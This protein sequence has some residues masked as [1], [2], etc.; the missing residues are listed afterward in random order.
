MNE[1]ISIKDGL[2]EK[3]IEVL[4]FRPYPNEITVSFL[5][6]MLDKDPIWRDEVSNYTHWMPLPEAPNE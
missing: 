4:V 1:W 5:S 2:P 3:Y 6:W